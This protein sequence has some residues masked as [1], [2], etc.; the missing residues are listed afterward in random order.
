[1]TSS[2]DEGRVA[3]PF[4]EVVSGSAEGEFAVDENALTVSLA[5]NPCVVP[6]PS[7]VLRERKKDVRN[8]LDYLSGEE[9][10]RSREILGGETDDDDSFVDIM[11]AITAVADAE[12]GGG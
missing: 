6:N 7:A 2:S 1:M 5:P 4:T 3:A 12:S 10:A 11:S 9:N 8:S